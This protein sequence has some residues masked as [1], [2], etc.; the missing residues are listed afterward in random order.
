[1]GKIRRAVSILA[2]LSM[3]FV[4]LVPATTALGASANP[5][6]GYA[7]GTKSA[8]DVATSIAAD[9]PA[10]TPAATSPAAADPAT[11]SPAAASPVASPAAADP[12]TVD[13]AT[14]DP[15]A[16]SPAAS[17]ASSPAATSPTVASPAI[18]DPTAASP[19][20]E[21]PA[22]ASPSTGTDMSPLADDVCEIDQ[23]GVQYAN[24]ADALADVQDGQTIALLGNI[25]YDQSIVIN[26]KAITFRTNGFTL[27]VTASGAPALDVTNGAINLDDSAGGALNA[28]VTST[29]Y[30][31]SYGCW[32]HDANSSIT[33]TNTTGGYAGAWSTGG[34][35]TIKGD[36]SGSMYGI[37]VTNGGTVSVVGDVTSPDYAVLASDAGSDIEVGGD[38]SG[39]VAVEAMSGAAVT[40]N[41]NA[42]ECDN[43][44]YATGLGTVVKV[45]GD[46]GSTVSGNGAGAS[47]G[48]LVII[49]GNVTSSSNYAAVASGTGSGV[50][51]GGNA[52]GLYG[53]YAQGG[54]SLIVNGSVTATTFGAYATSGGTVTVDGLVN[55]ADGGIYVYA[56]TVS[57]VASDGVALTSKPGYLTYADE[58]SAVWVKDTSGQTPVDPTMV[59]LVLGGTYKTRFHQGD[60]L[61]N[62]GMTVT[63]YRN[64]GSLL[65]VALDDP[66]LSFSG[67]DGGTAGDQTVTVSYEGASVQYLV[68]VVSSDIK[69]EIVQTG[70]QYS[71]LAD[72]LA[73]VQEGQ[74]IKLLKDVDYNQSINIDSMDMAFDVDGHTLNVASTDLHHDAMSVTS[75]EVKL[76]DSAGGGELNVSS[77]VG[78]AGLD[79]Y[80]GAK[81][82]VTNASGYT[83]VYASDP[84]SWSYDPCEVTV[85]GNATST[86]TFGVDAINSDVV[87]NGDVVNNT[88]NPLNASATYGVSAY[89]STVQVDGDVINQ[90]TTDNAFG[91]YGTAHSSVT[92]KGDICLAPTTSK[93]YAISG[94]GSTTV[95]GDVSVDLTATPGASSINAYGICIDS[96]DVD[97]VIT[98]AGDVKVNATYADA[99]TAS[100]YG[101][102][103]DSAASVPT[104]A[105]INVILDGTITVPDNG[106]YVCLYDVP[107]SQSDGVT[108][109]S[110]PG[111]MEYTDGA[112]YV[113]VK[114]AA[115]PVDYVCAIDQT[116][117]QYTN[118]TDALADVQDGQ[119]ITLLGNID[120][121]QP[122]VING[123]SITFDTNGFTLNVTCDSTTAFDVTNGAINLDDSAGG[124]LNA[125]GAGNLD[126]NSYGCWVH[127]A[128]SS[129]TVTNITGAYYG[130]W[131]DG[132]SIT[133]KGDA[134]GTHYGVYAIDGGTISV[135]GN[136]TSPLNDAV[137][138]IGAGSDIEVGGNVQGEICGAYANG[139][140][141][142]TVNGSVSGNTAV[143][144]SDLGTVIKVLGDVNSTMMIDGILA[145]K[146]SLIIVDGNATATGGYAVAADGA[147][148]GVLIGGDAHGYNGVDATNG[149]TIV[150]NGN[151]IATSRGVDAQSNSKVTVDSQITVPEGAVYISLNNADKVESDGVA[152]TSKPGYLAYVDVGT[153]VWVKDTSG[154]TPIVPSM[155]SL[156]LGGTYQTRFHQGDSY[157]NSGMAITGYM[158]DGFSF[159]IALDD[160][161]LKISGY[162]GNTPGDQTVTVSYE[163]VSTQYAVFV[164]SSDMKVEIVQTGVQYSD[165][166]D[167]LAAVQE[168][169][170]IKLLKDVSYNQ[171]ISIIGMDI[172]FDVNGYILDVVSAD[173]DNAALWVDGCNVD[174]VDSAGGGEFNVTALP[175]T[176]QAGLVAADSAKVTVTNVQGYYGIQ[177][178]E[179]SVTVLGNVVATGKVAVGLVNAV[180]EI[181]GDVISHS[182]GNYFYGLDAEEGSSITVKGDV[183]L[184]VAADVVYGVFIAN[185]PGGTVTVGGNVSVDVTAPFLYQTTYVSAIRSFDSI[186]VKGDVSVNVASD[187][188]DTA[189]VIAA[190]AYG[191]GT[192]T[193]DG[194]INIPSNGTYA[195]LNNNPYSQADGVSSQSNP[196]Y[197]EYNDGTSY[198]WVKATAEPVDYVCAIDQTGVK[199]TNL[200]D[201]LADVQD[202]QTITL[203][204]NIDYD[205]PIVINGKSITFD[206]NGFVLDVSTDAQGSSALDVTNGAINLDDSAG[207]AL[208]ATAT[209][210]GLCGC[211]VHDANSSITVTNTTGS[212]AGAYAKDGTIT[213]KGD[214]SSGAFGV[215]ADGGTITVA[216]DVESTNNAVY[217]TGT[218]AVVQVDGNVAAQNA[219]GAYA[220]DGA[221]VSVKGDAS[222]EGNAAVCSSGDGSSIHVQGDV[223]GSTFGVYMN[224]GNSIITV[225]GDVNGTYYGVYAKSGGTLTVSG[226]INIPDNGIYI[227]FNDV[228]QVAAD[229]VVST[230]MPGYLE[231]TNG[232]SIVWVKALTPLPGAPGSGD[233]Y[234]T[235]EVTMDVA[236]IVAQIVAGGGMQLTPAQ[237]AA[238]DMDGD[239]V[240][241]M[242]DVML[243]MQKA[244]GL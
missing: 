111:Y 106:T 181:D 123:K 78:N 23:T 208:N 219:Y 117:V 17:P 33:V 5:L 167:A 120:Y 25:D 41:G 233:L 129:V 134:S 4:M 49:D 70:V 192:A 205:Q 85:L 160:P 239:G 61:D 6:V 8:P 176:S 228:D 153:V 210:G 131:A 40:I 143:E 198:V 141:T 164:V 204:G 119:T 31:N 126:S 183:S 96:Q 54:A 48:A 84:S 244:V 124:A 170:T 218:G 206:T 109:T 201:A 113:W 67:F 155:A 44:V 115:E 24:L 220:G 107:F 60:S 185:S 225:E 55:V 43:G 138:A 18:G 92:V 133:V 227:S 222:S 180:A 94:S 211:Y 27:N 47:N 46:A 150:V 97:A 75:C 102:Y 152:F 73:D 16:A 108:S 207:G 83:A 240:L 242:Y 172:A 190:Y 66:G 191:S 212:H 59:K 154:Q 79:A 171:G 142:I 58:T 144:S 122:I 2:M 145:L 13:P 91:V 71:D 116:G 135:V 189:T 168:G 30:Q 234:G 195:L 186:I 194:T 136:V 188:A 236:M 235:G 231:Y 3:L 217:A 118:L 169:Q 69:V 163:G 63:G 221:T 215:Y 241:T 196:G 103:I 64:D 22:T 7:S 230:V 178:S 175:G 9:S 179:C 56:N 232:D 37:H 174:L 93:A 90:S 166:A 182:S 95:G 52:T 151:V 177:G 165:L 161:G 65:A 53:V 209:G 146:G 89:N 51:I 128:D 159:N 105:P 50:V 140:S 125:V 203:L 243:I 197:L 104:P 184:T 80:N 237:T 110:K 62:S 137:F 11:D 72:A 98:V 158:D 28:V 45:L 223:T 224:E 187:I 15:A 26:G 214:A 12:A 226:Q 100:I 10:A 39:G 130:A 193:I 20:T 1:M 88:V 132:G 216:G 147:G 101:V 121:D 148:S 29:S 162:D 112:N 99:V 114:A 156:S 229:G 200:T 77:P 157:S 74:T 81:V 127:D 149:A 19:A 139:G 68:T 76:L 238:V 42:N 36:V 87:V 82:T 35:I 199:Y 34:S 38:V 14:V 202:G 32:A 57:K 173:S 86:G 213:V 21:A